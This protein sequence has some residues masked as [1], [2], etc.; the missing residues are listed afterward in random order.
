MVIF[1]LHKTSMDE[2]TSTPTAK[3]N[4]ARLDAI[5]AGEKMVGIVLSKAA[6]WAVSLALVIASAGLTFAGVFWAVGDKLIA[7]SQLQAD[8][9]RCHMDLMEVKERVSRL[10]A[11]EKSTAAN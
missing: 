4:S 5:E 2:P 1:T 10:E 6:V 9:D 7:I 11:R 8:R 3:S